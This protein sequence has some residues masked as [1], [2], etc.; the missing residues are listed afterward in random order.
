MKERP[1][2]YL[3]DWLIGAAWLAVGLYLG[4]AIGEWLTLEGAAFWS[5]IIYTFVPTALFFALLV[6]ADRVLERGIRNAFRRGP[7][8]PRK[9]PAPLALLMSLPLGLL[10]G[11]IGAQF[12]LTELLL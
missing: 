3:F 6:L 7:T 8:R 2:M 1:R 10:I 4:L 12:G 11:V 9:P 5:T